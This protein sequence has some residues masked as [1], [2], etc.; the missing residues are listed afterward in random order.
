MQDW[1]WNQAM[2]QFAMTSLT[3]IRTQ[4][5]R[6]NVTS[7]ATEVVCPPSI[8][9]RGTVWQSVA[10]TL[11]QMPRRNIDTQLSIN[12]SGNTE[13]L[14]DMCNTV[15]TEPTLY[16]ILFYRN[17]SSSL[18]KLWHDMHS[19]STTWAAGKLFDKSDETAESTW[20]DSWSL[21]NW[22][23]STATLSTAASSEVGNLA[24]QDAIAAAS[25]ACSVQHNHRH[26][27]T[28]HLSVVNCLLPLQMAISIIRIYYSLTKSLLHFW[29]KIQT[30]HFMHLKEVTLIDTVR[31]AHL[32]TLYI[33][34]EL[35]TLHYDAMAVLHN[36]KQKPIMSINYMF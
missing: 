6:R 31:I 1:W 25:V 32:L 23:W 36:M 22:H 24:S 17:L 10:V 4:K 30:F 18:V 21:D 7:S 9:S 33:A 8:T 13:Q 35:T 16:L 26:K 15:T 27:M 14:P 19:T 20:T 11:S 2:N 28:T 12:P 29:H 3:T 5:S 34:A